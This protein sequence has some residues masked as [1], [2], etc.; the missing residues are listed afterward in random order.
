MDRK[1]SKL[2]RKK[3]KQSEG[4]TN[5]EI[6]RMIDRLIDVQRDRKTD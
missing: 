2:G 3:D 6:K 1:N 5:K 4:D